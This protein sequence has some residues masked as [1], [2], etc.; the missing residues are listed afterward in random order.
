MKNA[1]EMYYTREPSSESKPVPCSFTYRGHALKF[2]TDSGVFSRGE[3]DQGSKLL[4]EALPELK[5]DVLDLGC[6]WGA[7]GIAIGKANPE[8]HVTMVDVNL[9]AL[10]LCRNNA[11]ANGVAVTCL[12]S[13]GLKAV[14][15]RLFD[16]IVTN[17]PI[18]AGKQKVYEMLGDAS[19]SLR[20]G[21]SLFLVI[22]K[23][24]GAE[25]CIRY[26]SGRFASVE[27]LDRSGGFWVLEAREPKTDEGEEEHV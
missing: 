26:L 20:P 19:G 11:D 15:G 23:Q 17:P 14:A 3:L 13:D 2:V 21:G 10:E 27:K 1:G 12:E 16:S 25:S 24:Q 4:L 5:G 9:R 8:A 22:R 7:L 6:G 18:R